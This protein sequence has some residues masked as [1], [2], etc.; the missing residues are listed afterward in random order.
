MAGLKLRMAS[1]SG[2]VMRGLARTRSMSSSVRVRGMLAM[3]NA[4]EPTCVTIAFETIAFIPWISETT[5]MMEVTATMLPSTVISV[6]SLLPQI[7]CSAS[8]TA[9]SSCIRYESTYEPTKDTKITKAR[10]L[11]CLFASHSSCSSWFNASRPSAR[12]IDFHGRAVCDL[13]HRIERA[14]HDLVAGLETRQ[15][16]EIPFAGDADLH[17][18]EHHL[19]V[20]G[21]EHTFCFLACLTGTS[22][23]RRLRRRRSRCAKETPLHRRRWFVNEPA[24]RV[25][26]HVAH[27]QRL[28]R[29]RDDVLARR[30]RDLGGAGEAGTHIRHRVVDR[31][32]HLE[33]RGLPLPRGRR[34]RGCRLNRTVA[35]VGDA[36]LE[37]VVGY[38][39]DR[40]HRGLSDSDVRNIGLVHLDL[41]LDGRHVR[42]RE[43][44][45]PRVVHRADDDVFT[46]LDVAPR[47][48]AVH[49]R[50]DGDLTEV[51]A[52]G[53]KA[54]LFLLD[55]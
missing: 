45:R 42:D 17:W 47:D 36:P 26:Q 27:G 2:S 11:V 5:V 12:R 9:S 53:G 16:F 23:R 50:G 38:R 37:H 35:D 8:R 43:Q 51:V 25:E 46:F 10:A 13:P 14:R 22:F 39:V 44:H 55:L 32:D 41:R 3:V 7:V 49:R 52:R 1:A 6:R 18:R 34:L 30:R 24:L 29:H 40:H 33:V 20:A 19:A 48:D 15:H 54:G 28:N 31:H 21:D 4:S